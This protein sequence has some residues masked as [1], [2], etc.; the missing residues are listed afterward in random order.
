MAAL[1]LLAQKVYRV[2]P[3]QWEPR[4]S[5]EARE[6]EECRDPGACLDQQ[7]MLAEED[8][9]VS[10]DKLDPQVQLANQ[11]LLGEEECL[12][13][14]ALRVRKEQV[15]IE[16][17]QVHLDQ[18]AI[19][20]TSEGLDHLDF[21]DCGEL[22]GDRDQ[23]AEQVLKENQEKMDKMVKLESQGFKEYQVD[24]GPWEHQE[25]RVQWV[26]KE[27]RVL[28]ELTVHL[29][30]EE[31]LARMEVLEFRVLLGQLARQEREGELDL[32]DPEA[33]K[34]CL[35]HQEKMENLVKMGLLVYKVLR[36]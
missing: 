27:M 15:E 35:A 32:L 31:I 22:L 25:T 11:E 21:K 10:G 14:T 17:C 26:I 30:P 28:L 7:E 19:L 24:Q 5:L 13:Q 18:R 20:E 4:E 6:K 2:S 9:G 33:S 8:Q 34:E 16:E 1:A 23:E 12:V 3:E 29:E 36:E